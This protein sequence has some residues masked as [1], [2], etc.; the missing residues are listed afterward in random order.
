[1][2]KQRHPSFLPQA[3][4]KQQRRIDSHGQHGGGYRLRDVVMIGEVFGVALEV[5]LE[6][7]V[8]RFHHDVVVREVQLVQSFDVN[9]K[10]AAS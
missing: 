2:L 5:D 7:R 9:G 8:A 6:T 1:M 10:R 3:L 4:T